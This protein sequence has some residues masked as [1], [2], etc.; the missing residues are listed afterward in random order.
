MDDIIALRCPACGGQIQVEKNLEKM[1]CLHCG[2]QLLLKQG[3]DGLLVPLLAR[4]L[5]A[6]ARM[7][8]TETSLLTMQTLK[9]QIK[10]LEGQIRALRVAFWTLVMQGGVKKK[11]VGHTYKETDAI[12]RVNQYTQQIV[13]IPA[14]VIGRVQ[15]SN[16]DLLDPEKLADSSSIGLTTAGELLAFYQYLIQ[17]QGYDQTAYQMATALYPITSLAPTLLSKRQRYAQ[18]AGE[19]YEE[20][21]RS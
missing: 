8:E 7:Q 19:L 9:E 17:P 4:D 20:F 2:T 21:I 6:S 12:R 5:N 11:Y 3:A 14:I 15:L 18:I 1:Y 13:G 10:D 16:D